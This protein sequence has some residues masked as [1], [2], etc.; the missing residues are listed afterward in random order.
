MY[1]RSVRED[2]SDEFLKNKSY[3]LLVTLIVL[4]IFIISGA[5]F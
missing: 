3:H 5:I 4:T 2:K 1:I